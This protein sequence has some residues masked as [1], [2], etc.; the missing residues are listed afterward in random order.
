M[1]ASLFTESLLLDT[2]RETLP[3]L[4]GRVK[5]MSDIPI[6]QAKVEKPLQIIVDVNKASSPD[7]IPSKILRTCMP[8]LAFVLICFFRL[9][10][11]S[12]KNL[13]ACQSATCAQK[14]SLA[15][16]ANF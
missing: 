3:C 9:S 12:V 11:T 16:P 8:D 14:G 2:A 13:E 6:R 10:M 1:I 4:L 15:D 7:G 5:Q